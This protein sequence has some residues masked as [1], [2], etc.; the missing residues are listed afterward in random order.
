VGTGTS[1]DNAT[2]AQTSPNFG[3]I[4]GARPPRYIQLSLKLYF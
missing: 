1:F 4:N 3:V 2:G